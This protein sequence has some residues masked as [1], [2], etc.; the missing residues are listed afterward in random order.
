MFRRQIINNIRRYN[1]QYCE[2]NIP[3]IN[4]NQYFANNEQKLDL[5]QKQ[6]LADNKKINEKLDDINHNIGLSF[7][8]SIINTFILMWNIV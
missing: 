8:Y 4:S 5:I 6:M 7:C 1:H 3:Q 2:K